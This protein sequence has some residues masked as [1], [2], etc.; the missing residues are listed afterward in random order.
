MTYK[1]GMAIRRISGRI[2]IRVLSQNPTQEIGLIRGF[3]FRIL[4]IFLKVFINKRK[5]MKYRVIYTI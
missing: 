4:A 1:L 2:R 5:G 3:V